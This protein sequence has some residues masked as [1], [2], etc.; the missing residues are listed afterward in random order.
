VP[1]HR[2]VHDA[3]RAAGGIAVATAVTP[4][5]W[6]EKVRGNAPGPVSDLV[7][8]LAVSPLPAQSDEALGRYATGVVLHVAELELPAGSASSTAACSGSAAAT[9]RRRRSA[10]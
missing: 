5:A 2:A 9:T 10:R 1:A 3:I 8:E 6:L 4:Q 7:T